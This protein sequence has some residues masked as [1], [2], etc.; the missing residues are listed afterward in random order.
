MRGALLLVALA[1]CESGIAIEVRAPEG[2]SEVALFL[3]TDLCS[4]CSAVRP[5]FADYELDGA[6][7]QR[8]GASITSPVDETGSAWFRFQPSEVESS[9]A[10]V[11]AVGLLPVS[12]DA[13]YREVSGSMLLTDIDVSGPRQ[14]VIQLEE[15]PASGPHAEVWESAATGATCG[16]Y[17][18][19]DPARST[20]VVPRANPDCDGA[21]ADDCD[22][23]SHETNVSTPRLEEA[24]CLTL[25][26]VPDLGTIADVCMIG[27]E[28]SCAGDLCQP[29]LYCAPERA[30][31]P[32]LSLSTFSCIAQT[33]DSA[34]IVCDVPVIGDPIQGVFEVCDRD[35]TLF[36][37]PAPSCTSVDLALVTEGTP[38]QFADTVDWDTGDGRIVTVVTKVPDPGALTCTVELEVKG[39][40]QTPSLSEIP[41]P[42]VARIRVPNLAVEGAV[43]P[44]ML[45]PV[46]L[47][48]ATDCQSSAVEL[49]C[50]FE[51]GLDSA[52]TCLG[53]TR[54]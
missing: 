42:L 50:R 34:R 1:G 40:Y 29:T 18:R 15:E 9:F 7:Y 36:P 30:C 46:P 37:I 6:I 3:A 52:T 19:E 17:V 11:L 47:S 14:L 8:D 41:L 43:L 31:Q 49:S 2:T 12:D 35:T 5:P 21:L 44:V 48:D 4:D 20:V 27:G 22:E 32:C 53:A 24:T 54:P 26:P 51:P 13:T 45:K 25:E 38:P 28:A 23:F 16:A 10:V 39:A 33:R